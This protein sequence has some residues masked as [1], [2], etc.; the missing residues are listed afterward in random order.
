MVQCFL[1]TWTKLKRNDG[2]CH[3]SL[4][5]SHWWVHQLC[6][7]Q[8]VCI[9][10]WVQVCVCTCLCFSFSLECLLF[11]NVCVREHTGEGLNEVGRCLGACSHWVGPSG[12]LCVSVGLW[13]KKGDSETWRD[14]AVYWYEGA[15]AVHIIY[16]TLHLWLWDSVWKHAAVKTCR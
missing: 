7:K 5:S 16:G 2:F 8:S 3:F 4:F 14:L 6:L 15:A 13:E 10:L 11:P 1:V 12:A 9:C